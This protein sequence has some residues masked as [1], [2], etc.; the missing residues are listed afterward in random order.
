MEYMHFSFIKKESNFNTLSGDKQRAIETQVNIAVEAHRLSKY[1]GKAMSNEQ[2]RQNFFDMLCDVY[3]N[4]SEEELKK[5]VILDSKAL[6]YYPLT[7]DRY[8]YYEK[9]AKEKA[10]KMDKNIQFFTKDHFSSFS[11]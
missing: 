3:S 9:L 7:K 4:K 10:E 2:T 11:K 5:Y 8:E 1:Y 6:Y